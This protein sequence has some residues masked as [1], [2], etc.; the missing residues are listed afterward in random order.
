MRYLI[1]FAFIALLVQ[2]AAGDELDLAAH[3]KDV[4]LSLRPHAGIVLFGDPVFMEVT[5][6]N[7][8]KE[9]VRAQAFGLL[10]FIAKERETGIQLTCN[11]GSWPPD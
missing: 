1:P 2:A 6:V 10:E 8:G 11:A 5:I 3:A 7:R 9:P 4:A